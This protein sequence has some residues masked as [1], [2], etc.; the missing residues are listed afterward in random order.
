MPA[1]L[2]L[3]TR[4]CGADA[5]DAMVARVRDGGRAACSPSGVPVFV[6]DE[7]DTAG[8]RLRTNRD[9]PPAGMM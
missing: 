4:P 9:L 2:H 1:Q 6:R 8:R 5:L 3:P 7:G